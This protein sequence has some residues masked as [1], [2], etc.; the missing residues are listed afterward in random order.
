MT[1][2]DG[3]YSLR[4]NHS[5][6]PKSE[7]TMPGR[8]LFATTYVSTSRARTAA[9]KAWTRDD[10]LRS[11]ATKGLERATPMGKYGW[12]GRAAGAGALQ[13][14]M[15]VECIFSSARSRAS[16][17]PDT[18]ATTQP[19]PDLDCPS[20]PTPLSDRHEDTRSHDPAAT[21]LFESPPPT[22]SRSGQPL[23]GR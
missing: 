2:K 9:A 7:R 21:S 16:S 18:A 14:N 11:L 17:L 20:H 4:I 5:T 10:T 6:N 3:R 19:L 23:A 15:A 22:A 8:T 12:G 1:D 13:L